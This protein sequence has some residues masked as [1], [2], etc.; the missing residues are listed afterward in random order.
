MGPETSECKSVWDES[1]WPFSKSI[2]FVV[3]IVFID[4]IENLVVAVNHCLP[5]HCLWDL[6]VHGGRES[7]VSLSPELAQGLA[8]CRNSAGSPALLSL[9]ETEECVNWFNHPSHHPASPHSLCGDS[10]FEVLGL[11][12]TCGRSFVWNPSWFPFFYKHEWDLE[13]IPDNT[14]A[15]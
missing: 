3:A 4:W 13:L 15:S 12:S 9:A 7:S 10:A 1:F 14:S 6:P 11:W 5:S 2:C 8:C